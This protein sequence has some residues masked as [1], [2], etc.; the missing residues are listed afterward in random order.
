MLL[1]TVAHAERPSPATYGE[2]L[3]MARDQLDKCARAEN[4]DYWH[5]VGGEALNLLSPLLV[6]TP[7]DPELHFLI[8]RAWQCSA[9]T[10][11]PVHPDTRAL[12]FAASELERARRLAPSGRF[13]REVPAELGDIE[14][15]LGRY[16]AAV[17]EYRRAI[18]AQESLARAAR[19]ERD[20][21][22]S[23]LQGNAAES[24][25]ALGR[26][27]E[28][29]ARYALAAKSQPTDARFPSLPYWGLA[30]ALDRDNQIDKARAALREALSLD[31]HL[32]VFGEPSIYFMPTGDHFYYEGLAH[33]ELGRPPLAATAAPDRVPAAD[34]LR[35]ASAAFRR[36][37][38]EQPASRWANRARAHLAEIA[39]LLEAVDTR[40]RDH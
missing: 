14:S 12:G 15:R 34:E 30:V 35:T 2:R 40:R 37:L 24:L 18:D 10:A 13:D 39:R 36:F 23:R 17:E 29:I 5:A 4:R 3:S 16:A 38:E 31:H 19:A 1:T 11:D 25:M 9:Q 32:E 22:L 28:A 6:E 7:D 20:G 8:G 33:E 21:E 26:L 27:D